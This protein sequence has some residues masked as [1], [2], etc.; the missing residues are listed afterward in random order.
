M[1]KSFSKWTILCFG[2]AFAIAH[3][4]HFSPQAQAKKVLQ[5]GQTEQK[6]RIRR[7]TFDY[8]RTNSP[9]YDSCWPQLEIA[10]R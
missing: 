6:T 8:Y 5:E 4:I 9:R 1:K 10:A 2:M 7:M 3:W